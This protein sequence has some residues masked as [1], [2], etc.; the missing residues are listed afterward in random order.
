MLNGSGIK[1]STRQSLTSKIRG[2]VDAGP[3]GFLML[4]DLF[5]QELSISEIARRTG[6][7]RGTVRKYH[8]SPVPPAPPKRGNKSPVNWTAIKNISP[9]DIKSILYLPI[10]L[11][12]WVI[13]HL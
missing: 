13:D 2:Y 3:G 1:L 5:N 12:S 6:H 8:L 9:P 4:R 10:A 11:F 7:S